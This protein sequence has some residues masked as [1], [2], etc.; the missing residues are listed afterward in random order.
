MPWLAKPHRKRVLIEQRRRVNRR[1]CE[2][3]ALHPLGLQTCLSATLPC[4]RGRAIRAPSLNRIRSLSVPREAAPVL[5]RPTSPVHSRRLH[6]SLGR[7]F[8]SW[9]VLLLFE[10]YLFVC[11]FFQ[12][13]GRTVIFTWMRRG[14]GEV[15][16]CGRR[17]SRRSLFVAA[18]WR[19]I[20][21]PFSSAFRGLFRAPLSSD[22]MK[23]KQEKRNLDS[24]ITAGRFL[25][26]A[27]HRRMMDCFNC[28]RGITLRW[29]RLRVQSLLYSSFVWT[30]LLHS[31]ALFRFRFSPK[32][33]VLRFFTMNSSVG[34]CLSR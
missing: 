1:R 34:L 13:N 18:G 21:L 14:A 15:T 6:H 7:P 33:P 8:P 19:R 10:Y 29:D 12:R 32:P 11:L 20:L 16:D 3:A 31:L 26:A 24:T 2:T 4:R 23:R 25:I 5:P 30:F 22:T 9:S 17:P 28:R 27:S